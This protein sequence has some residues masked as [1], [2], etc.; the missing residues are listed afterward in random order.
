MKLMSERGNYPKRYRYTEEET[1]R[2][3][4]ILEIIEK[5]RKTNE[6]DEIIDCIN[7]ELLYSAGEINFVTRCKRQTCPLCREN[8]KFNSFLKLKKTIN[9]QNGIRYILITFNGR[10]ISDLSKLRD[11]VTENN[12]IVAKIVRKR[13]IQAIMLGYIK[14]VEI[15][16]NKYSK[17]LLP[18]IHLLLGV[19]EDFKKHWIRKKEIEKLEKT[20]KKWK[21]ET[22]TNAID[23]KVV[24]DT[25]EDIEKVLRYITVAR[26]KRIMKLDD[27]EIRAFFEMINDRKRLFT[28]SGI[29]K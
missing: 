26:K 17:R 12:D 3:I 29:F 6:V 19:R 9:E 10:K 22:I 18:H 24:K 8:K 14:I 7:N 27:M 13:S 20:W 25:D 16:Y 4:E 1:D 23:V 21:K 2:I 11:E 15:S 5:Y 28:T